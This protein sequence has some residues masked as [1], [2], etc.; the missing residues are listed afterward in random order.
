ME[1]GQVAQQVVSLN[2]TIFDNTFNGMI[3][4]QTYSENIMDGFI[5]QFPWVTEENK[6]PL[7][8]SIA[9]MKT[10]RDEYKAA[11]DKG[12]SNLEELIEKK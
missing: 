11:V 2:R 7:T 4:M 12:F 5:R 9:F 3:V 8:E 10:M 1:T 6:K